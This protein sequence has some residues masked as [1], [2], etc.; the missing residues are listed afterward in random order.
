MPPFPGS[1]FSPPPPAPPGAA[2][3]TGPDQQ[4]DRFAYQAENDFVP[5][6]DQPLSTFSIDVDTASYTKVRQYVMQQGVRPPVD[7][8]RIEE[9]INY[10]RYDY[11]PPSDGQPIAIH[12]ESTSCPWRPEHRLVR[13]GIRG[14]DLDE[15]RPACNLVFLVDVSG[16]MNAPN[17]L[18]LVKQ[19][20]EMLVER[21]DD[22]DRVAIVVYAG[23][24]GLAL[25]STPASQKHA[26]RAALQRL[27]A[28][29]STNGGEGIA[30]AYRLAR[31][32]FCPGGVNRVLLCTD[33]DFNV[34]VTS[35]GDLVRLA[36]RHAQ[37]N[38]FLTVLGFGIGNHND[39]LLE[40]ISNQANGNYAF[41]DTAS[42][43]HKVLVRQICGTLVTVAK[44]VK[45]QVE[46]NPAHATA[47]RLVGYENR[48]LADR[49][50]NDDRKDAG[51]MG[52]GH[53]V[54]V[55]YEVVPAEHSS[56]ARPSIDPLK[57]QTS[58]DGFE[59][60]AWTPASRELLTVKVRYKH[61]E[62]Q[63]S[64]RLTVALVDQGQPFANASPDCRFAAAVAAYGMRLRNSPYLEGM[65]Y[66]DI[67]CIADEGRQRDID[68]DRAEFAELVARTAQLCDQRLAWSGWAAPSAPWIYRPQS[69]PCA[70]VDQY[71]WRSLVPAGEPVV[72]Y[73][74]AFVL[75]TACATIGIGLILVLHALRLTTPI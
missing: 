33:G 50:F 63:R 59:R 32:N 28:G 64:D 68:G 54:T 29:G 31:E 41:I 48:Q 35:P 60:E 75:M 20:L 42:E 8:V 21:L 72:I 36:E 43:A 17:R 53:S 11:A 26:I 5:V 49:D 58:F 15:D 22:P 55:L 69:R 9:F 25:P 24:A 12:A 70:P 74:A 13:I 44:D 47:Y 10:F 67:W 23:S 2:P 1:P 40:Q 51:D 73:A 34:G 14:C 52:A 19:G 4:G 46:F 71:G 56:A 61:P 38:V 57:Y 30:L 27:Q 45:V 6:G 66:R 7:A 16:S 37:A 18:P 3:G 62:G 39:A 65:S